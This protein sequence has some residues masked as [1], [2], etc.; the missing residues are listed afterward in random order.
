MA[1]SLATTAMSA[2]AGAKRSLVLTE[3]RGPIAIV[4]LNRPERRNALS[5]EMREHIIAA[6]E[7]VMDLDDCRAVVLTGEGGHFCAG[8]DLNDFALADMEAGRAR[9]RRAHVLPRL[10]ATGPKPVIAAVEGSAFGA[11]LS[12]AMACDHVVAA[13]NARFC[14]S[15]VKAGLMP[16]Y[17]L[18]WSMQRRV[19][20]TVA[21]DLLM[22]A[23]EVSGRDALSLRMTNQACP[24]GEALGVA[25]D[26]AADLARLAPLAIKAIKQGQ[27]SATNL[28]SAFA[29][30]VEAQAAL[31][32]SADFGEAVSAFREKRA[33]EFRGE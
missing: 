28:E 7:A 11:G 19:G 33:P 4:T 25:L 26:V 3:V 27:A 9:M 6:L 32:K 15:F 5:V 30:E 16:D 22:R 20:A 23:V 2:E 31:F 18:I 17:G 24:A 29:H 10:I 12:L 14:A 1:R 13:E 8:G 21:N